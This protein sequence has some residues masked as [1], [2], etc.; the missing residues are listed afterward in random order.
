MIDSQTEA[1]MIDML[2]SITG[3]EMESIINGAGM[4]DQ[5]LRQLVLGASEDELVLLFRE[6]QDLEKAS[7]KQEMLKYYQKQL[8]ILFDESELRDL[9]HLRLV[10]P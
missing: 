5:M 6:R 10:I 8:I 9:E 2:E 4:R 1:I 3:E 7:R